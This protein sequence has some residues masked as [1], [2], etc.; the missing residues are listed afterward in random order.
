MPTTAEPLGVSRGQA[1]WAL[2]WLSAGRC[3]AIVLGVITLTF[4]AHLLYVGANCP[5]DLA[6]D[7]AYYWDWSRQLDISYYSKGPLTAY[8]IRASCAIFGDTAL[9][10]RLPALFMRVG[11]SLCTFWLARRLFRSERLA[12]GAVLLGYLAPMMM[13]AGLIMTTD[14]PFLFFWALA[15]CLACAAILDGRGWAWWAAGAAV[16][17]G[18]LTKF[19]MPLWLAGLF[20][21]LLLD[22]ESRHLL[23]TRGPWVAVLVA[24]PFTLP[25]IIWNVRHA[26]VTFLHV[27]ED[28]G[29][30]EGALEARNIIDFWTGQMCVI[31]PLL[32]LLIAAGVVSAIYVQARRPRE[33]EADDRRALRFLLCMGLPVFLGV[34]LSSLRKH[35]SNNWVASSY[36]AC[37][38]LTAWFLS[39]QMQS[40]RQWRLWRWIFYPAVVTGL[41]LVL[42]AH[43]TELLYPAVARYNA[44]FPASA[45]TVRKIDPTYR[46]HGWA[47]IGQ[48]VSS[49]V[50]RQPRMLLMAAE[51]Q[52]AAE[53][54]FY[55]RGEPKTYC[56][57]SYFIGAQ[58]EP[59][60]QFDIWPDRRLEAAEVQRRGMLG[61]DAIYLGAMNAEMRG[62]FAS[63]QRLPDVEI[64]R[65]GLEVRRVEIWKCSGFRGLEWP[66][67]DGR[68][69]K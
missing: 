67:W 14:P 42:V 38:I 20:L 59:F 52:T 5:M 26:W 58:R 63:V 1:A 19:S 62:A 55:V 65:R 28:V 24:L 22:R 31:G 15:T 23:R 16:G 18:F 8:L 54:A 2:A 4:V 48:R 6:E 66:G 41:A 10:V 3:R 49:L 56:A 17:L 13:A 7:E 21:F 47:E 64:H 9:A 69:N 34:M 11:I 37:L 50:E 43:N 51:Y 39:R 46:L 35:A 29:V 30:S 33:G 60:S 57:G 45:L 40:Q 36:F 53:L 68:Y 61:W 25:V 12:L 44:A 32:F 27:S